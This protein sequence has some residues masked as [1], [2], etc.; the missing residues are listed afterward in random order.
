MSKVLNIVK[1]VFAGLNELD[2]ET[3]VYFCGVLN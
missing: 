1:K 2:I 3:D